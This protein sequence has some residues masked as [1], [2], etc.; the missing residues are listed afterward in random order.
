MQIIVKIKYEKS[1]E[2]TKIYRD[3]GGLIS[4]TNN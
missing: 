2:Q 4:L 1:D 3:S